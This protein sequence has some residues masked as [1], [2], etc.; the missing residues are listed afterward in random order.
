M[1]LGGP[2]GGGYTV[3]M[4]TSGETQITFAGSGQQN[5]TAASNTVETFV[6]DPTQ[7]G[8]SVIG[9]LQLSDLIDVGSANNLTSQV[10]NV[11]SAGQYS[12]STNSLTWWDTNQNMADTLTVAL[13]AGTHNL[14]LQADHHSFKVV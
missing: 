12:V 5:V 11:Q 9:N 7:Q 3:D 6:M 8:G 13:A 10:G 14:Q 2:N 1:I 4:G